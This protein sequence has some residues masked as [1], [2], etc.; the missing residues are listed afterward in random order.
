MGKAGDRPAH[1]ARSARVC[2]MPVRPAPDEGLAL[3]ARPRDDPQACGL[4]AFESYASMTCS[5][6]TSCRDTRATRAD[7]VRWRDWIT[8]V[9]LS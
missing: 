2:L 5:P 6:P 1:Q 8:A 4:T 7:T 9:P 3:H